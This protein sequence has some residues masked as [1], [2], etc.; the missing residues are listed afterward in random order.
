VIK[1]KG[2]LAVAVFLSA[3]LLLP[4]FVV[5]KNDSAEITKRTLVN[6]PLLVLKEFRY[7]ELSAG[8]GI[9]VLGGVGYHFKDRDEIFAFKILKKDTN[10]TS[11]ILAK[12]ALRRGDETLM[13]GGVKVDR[14]DGYRLLT[15]KARYFQSNQIVKIDTPFRFEG[16]KFVAFGDSSEI[17]MKNKKIS[18][19]S[20]RAKLNY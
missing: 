14:S 20:I 3:I 10:F 5:L 15:Q 16:E 1:K 7:K 11:T 18:V 6:T 8:G 9:E 13:T 4:L 2:L 12:N 19:N 17:D